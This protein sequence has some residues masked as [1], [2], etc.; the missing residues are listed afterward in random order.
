MMPTS[1]DRSDPLFHP[2]TA[3]TLE[4]PSVDLRQQQQAR[5]RVEPEAPPLDVLHQD[6]E[7]ASRLLLWVLLDDG[8]PDRE[9]APRASIKDE[10]R[11]GAK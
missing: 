2:L 4:K 6:V 1:A 5:S 10:R 7:P 8:H 3:L 9:P 11:S